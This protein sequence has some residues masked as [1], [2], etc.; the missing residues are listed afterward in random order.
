MGRPKSISRTPRSELGDKCKE[1]GSRTL[2]SQ[3]TRMGLEQEIKLSNC[4]R[5]SR[6]PY[7]S[8]RSR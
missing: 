4:Y 5:L 6:M 7:S 8:S 2:L 3:L 1:V